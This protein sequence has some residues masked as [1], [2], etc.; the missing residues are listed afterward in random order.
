MKT[1]EDMMT[2]EQRLASGLREKFFKESFGG[3]EPISEQRDKEL[4]QEIDE[5]AGIFEKAKRLWFIG[6]GT[7][8]ELHVGK[9]QRDHKDHDVYIWADDREEFIKHIGEAGYGI[10]HIIPGE[11]DE[12]ATEQ[13]ML[14]ENSFHV[15]KSDGTGVYID[16]RVLSTDDAQGLSLTRDTIDEAGRFQAYGSREVTLES[17]EALILNKIFGARQL[18]FLDI[19]TYLPTLSPSERER[20]DGYLKSIDTTFVIG[21]TETQSLDKLMQ[22]AESAAEEAKANFLDTKVDE[23][24]SKRREELDTAINKIF[25]IAMR[26]GAPESFFVETKK[27]FGENLVSR[28]KNEL[29]ET[30]KFMFGDKKPSQNEFREFAYRA[31]GLQQKLEEELKTVALRTKRWSVRVKGENVEN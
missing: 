29:K 8:L 9:L 10:F 11:D 19:K 3:F 5:V 16:L 21:D 23:V 24:I 14:S 15:K 22:L 7:A 13:Q 31:F 26:T 4:R 2:S 1:V 18:D 6:G 30:A 17:K 12:E 27:E 20:L 28:R 25:E